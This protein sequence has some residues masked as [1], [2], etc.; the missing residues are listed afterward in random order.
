MMGVQKASAQ[1]FYS[2]DLENH[3][4]A[5]HLLREVDR[6]LDMDTMRQ[7]LRPFY[8]HT[9][10]PS[11]D[12]E[13][14]IRMLVIGY[15]M[16]IRSERRLCQ[17]VHLN[18]AYRWFCRLGLEDRVPDHSTFSR[19]RHGK[20]R[21]SGLLRQVF[22]ATVERCLKEDLVSGEGFAVD[23]SL[24]PADANKGRS[25]AAAEWS[26]DVARAAGNRAAREYLETL[27]DAAFGA[28]SPVQPKFVAKSDPAAQW[29]RADESRPY[30]AYATNYLIDT[31]SSV[32]MDVAATRAIRQAEVGASR[33]MIDRTERRFGIRPEWLAADT[34]Y[35]NA[36]NLGWLVEERQI[37]PF[38]P[39]IDK[40]ERTDGTW[41]RSDFEWDPVN[42]QYI[43]PEGNALRSFR[44]N[45]ADPSRGRD[46]GGT[47]KYR[48]LKADCQACPSKERCCPKMEFRA[49]TREEHEDARDVA[50]ANRKTKAY[51]ISRDKRKK[52]EMLFAHLKRILNLTRLRLRGPNGARDEFLLA[53]TAQNLRKLAKLRPA[54]VAIG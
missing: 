49:V 15:V 46:I 25:L 38:I 7:Q 39:V 21:E 42:D 28:A 19:Y 40:A 51:K 10:R 30:F 45:Y 17:E 8:S 12:P 41:S 2:F 18:L 5:D 32:I 24:I 54:M 47:R 6:F 9:G 53:A 13:L 29:T 20:F 43:C 26:P 36:E 31:K 50:R 27:D 52:V 14:I 22:E 34:A 35:G 37:T 11:I 4:P 33:T 3:V 23:A 48:A 1:L 16:G 44:R